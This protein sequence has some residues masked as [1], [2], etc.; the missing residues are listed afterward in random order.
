MPPPKPGPGEVQ[1][2]T[3][4]N[5]PFDKRILKYNTLSSTSINMSRGYMVTQKML[6]DDTGSPPFSGARIN[7]LYN[8]STISVTYGPVLGAIPSGGGDGGNPIGA[9]GIMGTIDFDLLFDRTYELWDGGSGGPGNSTGDIPGTFNTEFAEAG[10][11]GVGVDIRAFQ[12]ITG[13][14]YDKAVGLGYESGDNAPIQFSPMWVYFGQTGEVQKYYGYITNWSFQ[15]THWTQ[16]M[17]PVRCVI[18][19]SMSLTP[20]GLTDYKTL[21]EQAGKDL[22]ADPEAD[23]DSKDKKKP[24]A[25]PSPGKQ[26]T[27][28]PATTGRMGR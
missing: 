2:I 4:L 25:T 9:V 13:V 22:S 19:V 27:S 15:I 5:P 11:A 3:I 23:T 26:G 10:A 6:T 1:G 28:G 20:T 12:K 8:P 17:L 18:S 21:Q 7:F 14:V 16:E 24:K